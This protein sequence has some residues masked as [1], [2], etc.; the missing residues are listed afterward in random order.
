MPTA[1][2]YD[3][4]LAWAAQ[5]RRSAKRCD[6]IR[7]SSLMHAF[8]EDLSEYFRLCALARSTRAPRDLSEIAQGSLFQCRT[9][10]EASIADTLV[11]GINP[12]TKEAVEFFS[13]SFYGVSKKQG[14]SVRMPL[15]TCIPT[16]LCGSACYAHDVLDATPQSVV[17][18]VINGWIAQLWRSSDPEMRCLIMASLRKPTIRAIRASHQELTRLP[19]GFSRRPYIRFSHVGEIVAYSDFANALAREVKAASQA[20]VDCVVYTRHRDASQLAPDLWVINFTLD[21]SSESRQ[22]WAPPNARL[23]YSAFNGQISANVAVNF[24]E[25][26]RHSHL[27]VTSG[28]GPVCPATEPHASVRT[29]DGC[30]CAKCF[31]PTVSSDLATYN[32]PSH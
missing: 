25:H 18:G 30:R 5:L 14:V 15:T 32:L 28:A 22:S 31:E 3:K 11:R 7:T 17:R 2:Y 9:T 10:L 8:K 12:I 16:K 1:T 20:S 13:Q 21:P 6:I 4:T 27:A 24:L 23:V 19:Q 26:H 29:C